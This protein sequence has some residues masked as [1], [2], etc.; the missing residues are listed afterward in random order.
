MNQELSSPAF[1][2]GVLHPEGDSIR[3]MEL[4][5]DKRVCA[6]GLFQLVYAGLDQRLSDAVRKFAR[7][8]GEQTKV[9]DLQRMKFWQKVEYV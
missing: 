3:G 4:H 2:F 5:I 7:A 6:F 8:K 9:A 1:R